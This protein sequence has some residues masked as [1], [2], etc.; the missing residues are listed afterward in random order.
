MLKLLGLLALSAQALSP[1]CV[2]TVARLRG[3]GDDDSLFGG[4]DAAPAGAS[5]SMADMMNSMGG[6]PPGFNGDPAEYEA[7]ME[8]FLDSPMMQEF[9]NDPEKMEQSRQALLNNPMAMQMMQQMPGFEEIIND[10]DKF[11]ERMLAS[12][13]QFDAMR[14]EAGKS[15]AAEQAAASEFDD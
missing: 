11:Q 6:M 12:K 10:K 9:L 13:A 5:T 4:D 3:G 7:A 15:S 2:S 14:K 8:Q 1:R